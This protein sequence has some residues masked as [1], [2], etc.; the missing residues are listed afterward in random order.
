MWIR[1]LVRLGGGPI[2]CFLPYYIPRRSAWL[3]QTMCVVTSEKEPERMEYRSIESTA[4]SRWVVL[5]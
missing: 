3:L 5:R 4:R 2:I 1:I